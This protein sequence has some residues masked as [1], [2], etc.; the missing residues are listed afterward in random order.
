MDVMIAVKKKYYYLFDRSIT[1]G[2]FK[3]CNIYNDSFLNLLFYDCPRNLKQL[4]AGDHI[5]F[6]IHNCLRYYATVESIQLRLIPINSTRIYFKAIK[7]N[8]EWKQEKFNQSYM[9]N[10][11]GEKYISIDEKQKG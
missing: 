7:E 3:Y 9:K 10:F 4:K 8:K 1:T 6:Y 2:K 5:Y 11:K